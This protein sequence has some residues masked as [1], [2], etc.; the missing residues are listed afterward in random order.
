MTKVNV[1]QGTNV[2][3]ELVEGDLSVGNNATITSER[4]KVVVTGETTFHGSA[5]VDCGLESENLRV[6]RSG[7]LRVNGD[8]SVKMSLDVSN[9]VEVSGTLK[10]ESIDVGGRV[11]AGSVSCQKMRVGGTAE[12]LHLLRAELVEIGG[13]LDA[14]GPVESKELRVG[15]KAKVG[16]GTVS[17]IVDVGG[18]FESSS[19]L[20][21]NELRVH[22]VGSLGA[23]SRGKKVSIS[24]KFDSRGPL[25]CDQL[26]IS[27]VASVAGDCSASSVNV[28]GKL[29]IS[30]S[31]AAS[32]HLAV[33]GMANVRGVYT[34]SSVRV[35]GGLSAEEAVLTG[36]ADVSGEVRTSKG[37]K[38]KSIVIRTGTRCSGP[39]IGEEV[40]VGSSGPGVSA[41]FWG[42]RIRL[43][44]GTSQVEDVY[45]SR[46]VVGPGS[47]A[48]R[49][50]GE[51]VELGSGCD[52]E[53][54]AYVKGIKVG[55]HVK[56]ARPVRKV[57]KLERLVA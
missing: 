6:E 10:A 39:I 24:G 43:Q 51:V 27:G 46:V 17:G 34:G 41:H 38:A 47:R 33:Q 5:S 56:I 28:N 48:R 11:K 23:D 16:G 1:P 32:D 57:D 36:A 2:N 20:D 42:Q 53:E 9:S 29:D 26:D 35:R 50:F 3:L 30:G 12:V 14:H 37:L 45:A 49:V 31:L 15:G 19:R 54:V 44:L 55:D 52:I 7:R 40:D 21:F 8:L 4:G 22:G 25:Q 18:R 13:K